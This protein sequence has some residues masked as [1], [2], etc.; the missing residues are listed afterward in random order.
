AT[1]SQSTLPPENNHIRI[2]ILGDVRES[3]SIPNLGK[4]LFE[5]AVSRLPVRY[6]NCHRDAEFIAK[7]VIDNADGIRAEGVRLTRSLPGLYWLN[8]FGAPYLKLIGQQRLIASPAHQVAGLDSGVLLALGAAPG[9][10]TT[11][12]YQKR[13]RE[14]LRHLGEK[15]FFD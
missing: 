3:G 7:N 11:P 9:D 12:D 1:S 14:V 8:F 6:G 5:A 2:E 13:E 4:D 10:W 15:F